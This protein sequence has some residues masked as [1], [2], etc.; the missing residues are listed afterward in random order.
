MPKKG[1]FLTQLKPYVDIGDPPSQLSFLKQ[2]SD[3][4]CFDLASP[5][6]QHEVSSTVTRQGE[7]ALG[8]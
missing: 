5:Q 4:G 6:S 7:R 3:V 1:L 8:W 2:L